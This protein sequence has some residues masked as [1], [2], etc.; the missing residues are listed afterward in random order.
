V[1]GKVISLEARD[2][3][4]FDEPTAAESFAPGLDRP[5]S[6]TGRRPIATNASTN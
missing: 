6:C 5:I 2:Y 4:G 3:A 1:A